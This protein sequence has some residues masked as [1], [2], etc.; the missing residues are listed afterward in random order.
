MYL[1]Q[2]KTKHLLFTH[3]YT[4]PNCNLGISCLC[5][6]C[7]VFTFSLFYCSPSTYGLTL[8]LYLCIMMFLGQMQPVLWYECFLV[9]HWRPMDG[10]GLAFSSRWRRPVDGLGAGIFIPVEKT[11]EWP[12]AGIFTPVEFYTP[13]YS[14]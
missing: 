3:V 6:S 5:M 1:V 2:S 12:W 11:N 8:L 14:R 9:V 7:S 13:Y 4:C 10:L